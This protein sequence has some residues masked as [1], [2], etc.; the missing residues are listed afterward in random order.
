MN[1]DE[2][3]QHLILSSEGI[4][5]FNNQL[6]D[7]IQKNGNTSIPIHILLSY[8]FRIDAYTDKKYIDLY[9]QFTIQTSKEL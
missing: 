9:K 3:K 5:Y 7:E 2:I 1:S 8:I 6:K 4:T